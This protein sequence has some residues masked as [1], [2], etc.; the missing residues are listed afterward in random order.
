MSV[1]PKVNAPDAPLEMQ[2][3]T[4]AESQER[5]PVERQERIADPGAEPDAGP[6]AAGR[7]L[8]AAAPD[9][10]ARAND[11]AAIIFGM[12]RA[13]DRQTAAIERIAEKLNPTPENAEEAERAARSLAGLTRSLAD[14]KTLRAVLVQKATGKNADADDAPYRDVDEL[15]RELSRKLAAFVAGRR[16]AVSNDPE[17]TGA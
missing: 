16:R 6:D 3:R 2:E 4:P 17:R 15:R 14:L 5:I 12:L 10:L 8:S 9:E 1:P 7:A 13:I 11:D